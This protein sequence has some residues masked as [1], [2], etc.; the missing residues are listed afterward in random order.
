MGSQSERTPIVPV[1]RS[2]ERAIDPSSATSGQRAEWPA[3]NGRGYGAG[4]R[5]RDRHS[6]PRNPVDS[7]TL[8]LRKTGT[9]NEVTR[10]P[11]LRMVDGGAGSQAASS[12]DTQ[13]GRREGW[14]KKP[15]PR[16]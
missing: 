1:G 14:S 8:P 6:P 7:A 15:R 5:S 10:A 16:V 9:R 11:A 4:A 3:K 12:G 2:V 13:A